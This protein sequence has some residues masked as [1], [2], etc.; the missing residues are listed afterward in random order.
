[1]PK[2]DAPVRADP[3]S[4]L[5]A[6]SDSVRERT[7]RRLAA[8]NAYRASRDNRRPGTGLA[9][10]RELFC[11]T[12][13][14]QGLEP[15]LSAR[16]IQRWA[17]D[18][19]RQGVLGLVDER[20]W[21]GVVSWDADMWNY[22]QGEYLREGREQL[23]R[24]YA[25]A[26][27]LA[28]E[29]GLRLPTYRHVCRLVR[30]MEPALAA[31]G[32]DPERLKNRMLPTGERD[33]SLVPAMGCWVADHRLL[34]IFVPH[35]IKD[36]NGKC[37]GWK[38][39]RP[40]L[41]M[42]LDARSW[43]P[44][45]WLF[46]WEDPDAD[47]T[48]WVFL[49]G[50]REHGKPGHVYLD[51]GKDF[52]A[53]RYSGGKWTFSADGRLKLPKGHLEPILQVLG[54]GCTFAIPYNARSKIVE[55]FFRIMSERF[56]RNFPTY[57]GCKEERRPEFVK[58]LL[59]DT[60]GNAGDWAARGYTLEALAAGFDRWVKEDYGQAES[61]AAS[62]KPLSAIAAFRELRAP[63]FVASRPADEDLA[64][65]LLPSKAVTVRPNGIYVGAHRQF[66]WDAALE[67]RAGAS[68]RD[69][70]MHVSYRYDLDDPSRIWVFDA[71][72]GRFLAQATPYIGTDLHPLAG[73]GTPESNRVGALMALRRGREKRLKGEVRE[74]RQQAEAMNMRLVVGEAA[75]RALRPEG[76]DESALRAPEPVVIQ[77]TGLTEAARSTAFTAEITESTENGK[78]PVNNNVNGED[79]RAGEGGSEPT[80]ALQLSSSVPQSLPSTSVWDRMPSMRPCGGDP[81]GPTK[82]EG[83]DPVRCESET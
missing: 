67:P 56:D 22:I 62:S 73:R 75:G 28:R 18:Y 59:K 55:P 47:R 8:V 61:P 15:R 11:E 24:I 63:A 82:E 51:N 71:E 25:R 1:V 13:N 7:R 21:C 29:S 80:P 17:A 32:R 43:M 41:T 20:H 26:E 49:R 83:D 40:W 72:T 42:Y 9:V 27:F 45:S 4:P 36:V 35:E 38:W 37:L 46:A 12:W 68:A 30:R 50:V 44:I 60:K 23:T 65:L 53:K 81:A 77:M 79:G 70:S 6:L 57:C 10:F 3:T 14:S 16:T 78:R 52:R 39:H 48:I 5:A 54:I 31:A 2:E 66:Y 33:W 58:K 34:D 69:R 74:L 64:L 76:P 19:E